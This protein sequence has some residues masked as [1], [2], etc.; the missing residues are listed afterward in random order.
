MRNSFSKAAA[1]AL[2]LAAAPAFADDG[3]FFVNGSLG[4]SDYH[5]PSSARSNL[6]KVDRQDNAA[7]LRLGYRWNSVVDYGVELGYAYLGKAKGRYE[8]D[9]TSFHDRTK[10]HGWTLGGKLNYD[11]TPN[12]YVSARAGWIRAH[13]NVKVSYDTPVVDGAVSRSTTRTGEYFGAGVGYNIN[14]HVS[15]GL[16]YDNY[17]VRFG[18]KG[19]GDNWNVGMYSLTGEYRF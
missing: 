1:L 2:C 8:T 13:N 7:A 16:A 15:V 5:L 6:S 19:R 10:M 4:Q 12:W 17:H 14:E 11:I 9:S 18:D 3:N